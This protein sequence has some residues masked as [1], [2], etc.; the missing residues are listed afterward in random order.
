[1]ID[2]LRDVAVVWGLEST[3]AR[4]LRFRMKLIRLRA[5]TGATLRC[6]VLNGRDADDKLSPYRRPHDS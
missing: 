5:A 2:S 3:F 6:T 1:M 4:P